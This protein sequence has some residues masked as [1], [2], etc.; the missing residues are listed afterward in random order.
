M[1]PSNGNL[2]FSTTGSVFF[3]T[4]ETLESLSVFVS[5]S[6]SSE[7]LRDSSFCEDCEESEDEDGVNGGDTGG[8]EFT[9][10]S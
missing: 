4:T 2:R 8:L 10:K 7:D 9:L 6:F 3:S 1:F 5:F